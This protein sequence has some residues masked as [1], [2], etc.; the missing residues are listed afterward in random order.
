M[1][2]T[3][4]GPKLL[5]VVHLLRSSSSFCPER[6]EGVQQLIVVLG[7][8]CKNAKMLKISLLG[9]DVMHLLLFFTLRILLFVHI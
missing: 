1:M 3:N 5:K 4:N 6:K 7:H 2:L 8:L 9:I